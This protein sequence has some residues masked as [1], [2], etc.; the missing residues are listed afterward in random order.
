VETTELE[1]VN[2]LCL[3]PVNTLGA[4]LSFSPK[5]EII[6]NIDNDHLDYYKNI[7]NIKKAFVDF[8]KVAYLMMEF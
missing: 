2:I 6:L 7:D 4:F 8:I 5:A 1:K 3:K